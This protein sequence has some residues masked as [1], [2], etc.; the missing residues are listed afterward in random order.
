MSFTIC[1]VHS[2]FRRYNSIKVSFTKQIGRAMLGGGDLARF[3]SRHAVHI[4]CSCWIGIFFG[5][6]NFW[7]EFDMVTY[8]ISGCNCFFLHLI[9]QT[10]LH[11]TASLNQK[12]S[13]C[14]FREHSP[15]V[16]FCLYPSLQDLLQT[17]AVGTPFLGD[18]MQRLCATGL[19]LHLT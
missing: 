9:F 10:D 1:E 12:C 6:S 19:N 14:H 4:L 8:P 5:S 18:P 15:A 11:K 16:I 7:E 3:E 2:Y 17:P 13:N